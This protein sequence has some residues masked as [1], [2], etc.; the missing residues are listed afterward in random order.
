MSGKIP[1]TMLS[2]YLECIEASRM[3]H[4]AEIITEME[5]EGDNG[6]GGLN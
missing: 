2:L 4:L 5:N 1:K 3:G 6:M